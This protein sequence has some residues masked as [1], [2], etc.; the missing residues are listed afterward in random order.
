M[1][2]SYSE[3]LSGVFAWMAMA[4]AVSGAMAFVI[5]RF[6][7]PAFMRPL[8]MI[9]FCVFELALV[10]LLAR[11]KNDISVGQARMLYMAYSVV[12]GI[13]L[14]SIFVHYQLGSVFSAF[15]AASL[16]FAMCWLA[17]RTIKADLSKYGSLVLISLVAL[18]VAEIITIFIPSISRFI[19]FVGIV[20]FIPITIYDMKM[21]QRRYLSIVTAEDLEKETIMAA[22]DLYLDLVNIMLRI[23]ELTGKKKD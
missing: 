5:S 19:T 12:S 6:F 16:M 13:T 15:L 14:S 18:L 23:L 7:A 20:I 8:V 3:Y 2:K 22:L 4:L 1:K 17:Q 9:I 11:N 21:L 10:F